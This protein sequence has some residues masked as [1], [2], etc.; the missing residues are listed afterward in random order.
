MALLVG[1][2]AILGAIAKV[3]IAITIEQVMTIII[4]FKK[5]L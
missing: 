1:N 2:A 3:I 4:L 5:K